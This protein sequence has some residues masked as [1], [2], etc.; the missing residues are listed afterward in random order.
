MWHSHWSSSLVEW[1]LNPERLHSLWRIS[2][3]IIFSC[4][5]IP[6]PHLSIWTFCWCMAWAVSRWNLKSRVRLV[7]NVHDW[8]KNNL[9]ARCISCLCDGAFPNSNNSCIKTGRIIHVQLHIQC[10]QFE[11]DNV[12]NTCTY[13]YH[14]LLINFILW[15]NNN[16]KQLTYFPIFSVEIKNVSCKK[17]G[18]E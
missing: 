10:I 6:C 9:F 8:M 3:N 15:S 4:R 11:Q 13:M 14:C 2:L 12:C 17:V 5:K 16:I 18:S 7:A 1:D